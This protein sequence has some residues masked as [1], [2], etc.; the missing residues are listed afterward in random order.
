[1]IQESSANSLQQ[2][3][4]I[5]TPN[6]SANCLQQQD[7]RITP[8]SSANSLQQQDDDYKKYL[9]NQRLIRPLTSPMLA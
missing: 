5:I 3:D 1:M 6:S 7:D 8:N 2:Q 4:N 9:Q